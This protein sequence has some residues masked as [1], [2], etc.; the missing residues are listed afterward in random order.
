LGFENLTR[1]TIF[2]FLITKQ[3]AFSRK[4]IHRGQGKDIPYK[5]RFLEGWFFFHPLA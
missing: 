2:I 4:A 1:T 5:L 3:N